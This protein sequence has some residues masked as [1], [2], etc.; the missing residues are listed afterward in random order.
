MFLYGVILW[1][2]YILSNEIKTH[3]IIIDH[4]RHLAMCI[5]IPK[6]YEYNV[7]YKYFGLG[8]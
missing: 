5:V 6:Q 1:D 8:Q 3:L 2:R 7:R 4:K